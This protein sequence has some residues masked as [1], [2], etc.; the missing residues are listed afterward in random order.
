M[1]SFLDIVKEIR[2]TVLFCCP[3]EV[4]T[5]TWIANELAWHV[6]RYDS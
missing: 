2:D 4:G 5:Q 1:P 6:S 3:T